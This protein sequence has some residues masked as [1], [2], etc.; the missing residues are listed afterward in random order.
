MVPW[1]AFLKLALSSFETCSA[2]L[3]AP[4]L[5]YKT[6]VSHFSA[7]RNQPKLPDQ[8]KEEQEARC[9]RVSDSEWASI[10]LSLTVTGRADDASFLGQHPPS[11]RPNDIFNT[12]RPF[13]LRA[14][15][16][17]LLCILLPARR[18]LTAA[19]ALVSSA[20]LR[21]LYSRNRAL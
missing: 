21:S 12:S 19:A 1:A 4:I 18:I 2:Q 7:G 6:S 14:P 5:D 17:F 9:V 13:H 3:T 10:S 8:A 16:W 15:F 20:L 11:Q